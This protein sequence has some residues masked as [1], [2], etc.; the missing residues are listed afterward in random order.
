MGDLGVGIGGVSIKG[1]IYTSDF[2]IC[3]FK[4]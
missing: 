4:R 2:L 3:F 1:R